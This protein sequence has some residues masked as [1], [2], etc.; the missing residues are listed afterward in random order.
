MLIDHLQPWAATQCKNGFA[1]EI[2][3]ILVAAKVLSNAGGDVKSEVFDAEGLELNALTIAS[4]SA[5]NLK[6]LTSTPAQVFLAA[7]NTTTAQLAGAFEALGATVVLTDFPGFEALFEDAAINAPPLEVIDRAAVWVE[8]TFPASGDRAAVAAPVKDLVFPGGVETAITFG[9]SLRGV[10]CRPARNPNGQCIIF[11]NTGGDPR[12]GIG[13]FAVR[14]GRDL[15]RQGV[16]SF[17]FDFSGVGDS[18]ARDGAPRSHIYEV[19]RQSEFEAAVKVLRQRGYDHI[20]LAGVCAGAHHALH[21]MASGAE[22]EAVFAVNPIVLTWN[23]AERIE[24]KNRDLGRAARAYRDDLFKFSTWSRVFRGQVDVKTVAAT[25]GRRLLARIKAKG[26]GN[27]EQALKASWAA[28][29]GRLR[30]LLGTDDPALD[31]IEA[32][33]G[34]NGRRLTAHPRISLRVEPGLD[35]GLSRARSRRIAAME[36]V[37]FIQELRP[38]APGGAIET[39]QHRQGDGLGAEIPVERKRPN[40]LA[41]G[42]RTELGL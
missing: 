1:R 30:F 12:A 17:R 21:A 20:I 22:V 8:R 2:C 13:R 42:S 14:G 41:V 23:P 28:H 6:A 32:H 11:T 33:F 10:L 40:G 19:P 34:A 15:V 5:F 36:L 4:L 38:S 29:P 25:I 31:N 9:P 18:P 3:E 39:V 26:G 35:H 16:A 37:R 27:G 24:E 7:Q